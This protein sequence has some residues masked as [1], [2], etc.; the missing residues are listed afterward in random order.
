MCGTSVCYV[1]SQPISALHWQS[2]P[3]WLYP[4]E[5][6]FEGKQYFCCISIDGTTMPC[7]KME[8]VAYFLFSNHL[9]L[10]LG[11]CKHDET[12]IMNSQTADSCLCLQSVNMM[13]HEY[14]TLTLQTSLE[15]CKHEIWIMALCFRLGSVNMMKH[16]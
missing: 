8:M 11:V 14:L 9:C 4:K 15:V 10:L 16:G 3:T 2:E 6:K 13:K 1:T 5:L 12:W 7:L